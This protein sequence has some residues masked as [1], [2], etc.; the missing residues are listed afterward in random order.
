MPFGLTIGTPRALQLQQT[1]Q[2]ELTKQGLIT[3]GDSVMAEYITIMIINDKT[4]DQITTEMKEIIGP[5][6]PSSFTDWLFEEA[7]K[8]SDESAA[9]APEPSPSEQAIA[10]TISKNEPPQPQAESSSSSSSRR[11]HHVPRNGVYQHTVSQVL[12]SS[13]KRSASA[14][15]PSPGH[16]NKSRRTDLPTGPR[17]MQRDGNSN[18]NQH[19]NSRSLLDRVGGPAGRNIAHDEIQ[20]RIDNIVNSNTPDQ[21]QQMMMPNGYPNMGGMEMPPM[22]VVN[23]LML[24]EMMMNQMALMAQLAS[25][26]GA[27]PG[28]PVPGFPMQGVMPGDM[29]MFPGGVPNGFQGASG[30]NGH[31]TNGRGRGAM[32]G[33]RGGGRGRGGGITPATPTKTSEELPVTQNSQSTPPPAPVPIV[34]PTPVPATSQPEQPSAVIPPARPQSPTLCKFTIK[35]TNP[36]CRY[37]HPSPVATVES[38]VVL[39]NEACPEGMACKDK[40]CVK[41]HA[42]PAVLTAPAAAVTPVAHPPP[43]VPPSHQSLAIP[44][45]YGLAC[46]RPGCMFSHPPRT[47]HYATPCRFGAACTRATCPFQHPEGR[48]LPNTFHRGLSTT[49]PVVNVPTPETGSMGPS[50]HRSVTFNNPASNAAMKE[51]LEKQVKELEEKKNQAEKAMKEAEAKKDGTKPVAITA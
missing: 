38:G 12:S 5:E 32:R 10:P 50:P 48:V 51:K 25:T 33:G 24:Q 37:S 29:G 14:R 40:D 15:S 30:A 41:G 47:N 42:S 26:I 8:G 13:S 16:P 17:A 44:C 22:G 9:A 11:P 23:P 3:E 18:S 43:S 34:A 46:T 21:Q 6:Y 4:A 28:Y 1:I 31:G 36:S 49:S 45:R 19:G 7:A 20:A 39:S 2:D 27:G 35:C